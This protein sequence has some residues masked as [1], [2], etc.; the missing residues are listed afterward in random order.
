[1]E[2]R[3]RLYPFLAQGQF[4]FE[5]AYGF[6]ASRAFPG[7]VL[8]KCLQPSFVVS[9]PSL[10]SWRVL[11]MHLTDP[12][13]H[14]PYSS[15]LRILV[16]LTAL[17][18]TLT[19]WLPALELHQMKSSTFFLSKLAH[20]DVQLAQLPV[21]LE[22]D[23]SIGITRYNY[24]WRIC[25]STRR[26]GTKFETCVVSAVSVFGSARSWPSLGQVDGSTAAGP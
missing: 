26:G 11:T 15:L 7:F 6:P 4:L 22:L 9:F 10:F 8:S 24:V 13:R 17:A 3:Q 5:C 14:H 21:P 12:C 18:L 23:V 20:F 19:A 1:M 25:G 2:R 16:L